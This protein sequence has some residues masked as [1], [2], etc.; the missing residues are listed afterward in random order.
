MTPLWPFGDYD[1]TRSGQ[2]QAHTPPPQKNNYPTSRP[3]DC[4]PLA[5]TMRP[6]VCLQNLR[7]HTYNAFHWSVRYVKW[8][9]IIIRYVLLP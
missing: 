3:H 8:V 6:P 7:L 5:R 2:P 1:I 4:R 9:G